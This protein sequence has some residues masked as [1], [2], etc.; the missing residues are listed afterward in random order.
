MRLDPD[1]VSRLKLLLEHTQTQLVKH[2]DY[3]DQVRN[4]RR[5]STTRRP[6]LIPQ[7]ERIVD[8]WG[9]WV[10]ILTAVIEEAG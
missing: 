4:G 1:D 9:G 6:A 7:K 2:Q 8:K 10:R 3:L 5:H